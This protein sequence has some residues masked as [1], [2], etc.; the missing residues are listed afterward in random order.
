MQNSFNPRLLK[1]AVNANIAVISSSNRDTITQKIDGLSHGIFTHSILRTLNKP[2]ADINKDNLIELHELSNYISKRTDE[3]S[4][5]KQTPMLYIPK[6]MN[7]FII[8][9]R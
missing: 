4:N 1:D 3:L 2:Y 9:K 6:G 5:G 8:L 7:N